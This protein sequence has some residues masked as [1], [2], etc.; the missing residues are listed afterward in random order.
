MPVHSS[1]VRAMSPKHA[2][3]DNVRPTPPAVGGGREASEYVACYEKLCWT[4]CQ[5]VEVSSSN[6]ECGT[7]KHT[8]NNEYVCTGSKRWI[9]KP[10]VQRR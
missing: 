3:G 10:S 4:Q 5:V 7:R 1:N 9:D 8:T 2:A 6:Y